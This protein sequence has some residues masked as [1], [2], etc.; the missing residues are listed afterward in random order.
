MAL[1][2]DWAENLKALQA[3]ITQTRLDFEVHRTECEG[4]RRIINLK[5]TIG[6]WLLSIAAPGVWTVAGILIFLGLK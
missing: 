5:L 1:G 4:I 2:A 6:L 3:L